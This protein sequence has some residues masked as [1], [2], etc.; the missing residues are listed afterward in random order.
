MYQIEENV[1]IN[2]K[3]VVVLISFVLVLSVII[4]GAMFWQKKQNL[5]MIKQ[6]AQTN[7]QVDNKNVK[8]EEKIANTKVETG[9]IANASTL[10]FSSQ[11]QAVSINEKFSLDVVVDPKGKKVTVADIYITFDPK[12]LKLENITPLDAFSLI[13]SGSKIDNEKGVAAISLGV[14]M[15]KNAVADISK[16]ATFNF[17]ALSSLGETEI[18]FVDPTLIGIVGQDVNGLAS[19]FST[20]I[21]VQ[22]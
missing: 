7:L 8:E 14:P 4:A 10:A 1:K 12:F 6:K 11:K 22:K 9:G 3:T 15:E 21:T 18:K 17:Q 5:K 16:I 13:L 20:A 19:S 2:K